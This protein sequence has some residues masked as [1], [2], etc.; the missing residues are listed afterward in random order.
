M[1]FWITFIRGILAI[2]L[3][4]ALL[5]RPDRALPMLGNFMGLYWLTSGVVGLR[6]GAAGGRARGLAL[7]AGAVGV[8]A[9]LAMLARWLAM[10]GGAVHIFLYVLGAIMI[11][12]G[13]LHVFEGLPAGQDHG[14]RGIPRT[15]SWTSVLLGVFEA[16][17]GLL[18]IL[19]PLE[20]V[21]GVYLA[22]IIWALL[23]GFVL[24]GD[25]LRTRRLR[26]ADNQ[27]GPGAT[28]SDGDFSSDP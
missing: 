27:R 22:A 10:D 16:V 1:A 13:L 23:G 18:L 25:A 26:K 15:R 14:S 20:P 21:P 2:G 4:A 19:Y 5:L 3:G 6:W 17:L 28:E 9:G 11:L 24:I 12:T 7:V 8:L